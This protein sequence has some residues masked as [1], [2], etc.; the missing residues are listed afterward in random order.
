MVQTILNVTNGENFEKD[1]RL[2]CILLR[3][4]VCVLVYLIIGMCL[5]VLYR[6]QCVSLVATT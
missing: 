3:K 2:Y 4:S 1:G 6:I 5:C